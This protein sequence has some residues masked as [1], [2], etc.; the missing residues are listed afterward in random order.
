MAAIEIANLL[1]AMCSF[2]ATNP[3]VMQR[4]CGVN[5]T[6]TRVLAGQYRLTFEEAV[7]VAL[8]PPQMQPEASLASTGLGTSV[9]CLNN[10]AGGIDVFCIDAAGG[11]V[12]GGNVIS[13]KLWRYPTQG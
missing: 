3:P 1:Q 5:P 12:D 7:P 11:L 13:F 10:G 6:I 4:T 2:T 8:T 9:A